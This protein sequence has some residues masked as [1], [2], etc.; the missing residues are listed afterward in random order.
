[1]EIE[2]IFLRNNVVGGSE[3]FS[4]D[5][6]TSEQVSFDILQFSFVKLSYIIDYTD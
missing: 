1:M 4:T 6:K 5:E 3:S 2:W